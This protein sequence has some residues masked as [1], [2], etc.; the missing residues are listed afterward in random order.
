MLMGL[1]YGHAVD[2]W[3]LGIMVYE[4]LT[5]CPPFD[6]DFNSGDQDERD[7]DEEEDDEELFN[8]IKNG[9]ADYPDDMSLA[10]MS[11]VMKVSVIT[12][13]SE[14]FKCNCPSYALECNLTYLVL[15]LQEIVNTVAVVLVAE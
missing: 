12:I 10:A 2:W 15:N 6:L 13:K 14:A 11:L 1:P 9:E 4:M 3:A 5:G 7:Y 8:K